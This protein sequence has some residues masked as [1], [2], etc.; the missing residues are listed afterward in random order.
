MIIIKTIIL[1]L[2]F[3]GSTS[4]GYLISKKYANR[5]MELKEFKN[6][7]NML[8]AK[9]KFTYE[10]IP[11]IFKQISKNLDKNISEIFK[12]ASEYIINIT[13]KDAW[14]KAIEETKETLCL[15]N[16]DINIIKKLGNMLRENRRRRTDK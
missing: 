7:I 15:N 8:E 4:I 10:P 11:E 16:E 6:A 2:I 14:N 9:I 12:K 5:V 3:G 1:M 13:T